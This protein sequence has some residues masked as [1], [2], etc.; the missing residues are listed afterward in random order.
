MF[1]EYSRL[2]SP[3]YLEI[4]ENVNFSYPEHLHICFEIIIVLAGEMQ[5]TIDKKEFTLTAGEALLIYPHQLH[6]LKSTNSK[7]ILC[8]FSQN[9]VKSFYN[10]LLDT[11]PMNNKF[12]PDEYLIN[13]LKRLKSDTSLIEKKGVLYS[14][15]SQF[16]KIS[17]YGLTGSWYNINENIPESRALKTSFIEPSIYNNDRDSFCIF[18]DESTLDISKHINTAYFNLWIKSSKAGHKARIKISNYENTQY[19]YTDVTIA[20][21][22]VWQKVCIPL[23]DMAHSSNI[24]GIRYLVIQ[25]LSGPNAMEK[26]DYISLAGIKIFNETDDDTY[27]NLWLITQ[28]TPEHTPKSHTQQTDTN[29]L[30]YKIFEFV[31]QNFA[32]ECTL[33]ELA[34]ITTY[35][36]AYLSRFFKKATKIS[37]NTYV[38]QFRLNHFCYLLSNSN[39]TIIS[40]ALN[41]GFK[42]LRTFNRNFKE[43]YGI[44]PEEYRTQ[45]KSQ[46]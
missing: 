37:F 7:H 16:H 46:L 14:L 17:Y 13:A 2:N 3:D 33:Y 34:K 18:S 30:L 24:K 23:K 27:K 19:L 40:C 39:D 15:C 31:E 1:Y 45:H 22:N 10:T 44:T 6:S 42:S 26:N 9:I 11:Q 29:K 12:Q 20:E 35:D 38:N 28:K 32:G 21:A 5:I 25:N 36:Y 43:Y 8:I 4:E 41:S